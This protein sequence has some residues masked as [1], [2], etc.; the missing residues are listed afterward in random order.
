[1]FDL[2][3]SKQDI[4][5]QAK[6]RKSRGFF[7]KSNYKKKQKKNIIKNLIIKIILYKQLVTLT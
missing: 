7:R 6:D 3:R 1:M 2:S 5:S 4:H